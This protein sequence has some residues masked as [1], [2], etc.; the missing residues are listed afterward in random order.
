MPHQELIEKFYTAF[1]K[2]DSQSMLEC[3]HKDIVFEDPAFG[4]LVGDR[5]RSMWKM[6]L[7]QKNA[8]LNIS[9]SISEVSDTIV[10]AQWQ[11][12]Y[13]FGKR[14]IYNQVRAQFKFKDGKIIEHLD[15]FNFWSWTKQALGWSGYLLGWTSFLRKKVQA[16]T[17]LKL[18][19][20]MAT[21]PQN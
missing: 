10:I 13:S 4:K 3:Y 16:K 18:D 2:G 21:D 11:A 9:F 7:S 20:F 19:R 5:A 1:S 15:A 8:Q 12:R 6:L 17:K 14:K